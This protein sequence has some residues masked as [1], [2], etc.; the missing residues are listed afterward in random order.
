MINDTGPAICGKWS[1]MFS[2][3]HSQV[4]KE[5]PLGGFDT[6]SRATLVSE[7]FTW[8]GVQKRKERPTGSSQ[9]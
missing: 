7:I 3:N 5:P 4:D 2:I 1:G 8:I 9:N 6:V